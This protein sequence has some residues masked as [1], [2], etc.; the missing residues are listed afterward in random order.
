MYREALSILLEGYGPGH[1]QCAVC[2]LE[3]GLLLV[4]EK[5]YNEALP[6]LEAAV[7]TLRS[8]EHPR[9]AEAEEL[10]GRCRTA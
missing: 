8:K 2:Q 1:S 9:I 4:A 3:L 7:V 6:M 10:I 5:R